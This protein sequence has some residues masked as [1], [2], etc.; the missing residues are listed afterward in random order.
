MLTMVYVANWRTFLGALSLARLRPDK[1]PVWKWRSAYHELA[2]EEIPAVEKALEK[3]IQEYQ[4]ELAH[5]SGSSA[6]AGT[7]CR[8]LIDLTVIAKDDVLPNLNSDI[9]KNLSHI[10]YEYIGCDYRS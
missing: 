6:I 4:G 2:A 8:P 10:G 1:Y 3:W 7:E 9:Y 5:H